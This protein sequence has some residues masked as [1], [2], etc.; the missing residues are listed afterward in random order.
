LQSRKL[1][2]CMLQH[3]PLQNCKLFLIREPERVATLE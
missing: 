3:N 1:L 2:V